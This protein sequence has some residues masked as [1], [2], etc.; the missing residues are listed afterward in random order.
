MVDLTRLNLV[1]RAV[2]VSNTTDLLLSRRQ[3]C[4]ERMHWHSIRPI[5]LA[6]FTH[7]VTDTSTVD[8]EST[9]GAIWCTLHTIDLTVDTMRE[10]SWHLVRSGRVVLVDIEL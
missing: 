4:R 5:F 2:M 7:T 3:T 8:M 1:I 6:T 10:I 9:T